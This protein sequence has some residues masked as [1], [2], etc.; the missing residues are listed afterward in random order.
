MIWIPIWLLWFFIYFNRINLVNSFFIVS[1]KFGMAGPYFCYEIIFLL[2]NLAI[3][4]DN[5]SDSTKITKVAGWF[6]MLGVTGALTFTSYVQF[7]FFD[8]LK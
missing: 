1:V 2:Y 7:T 3:I 4:L 6:N 8:D 5:H